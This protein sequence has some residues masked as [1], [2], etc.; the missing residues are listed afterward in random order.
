MPLIVD[1]HCDIAWNIESFGRDYTRS[2]AESREAEKGSRAVEINEETLIGIPE[3]R[4]GNVGLVFG[5]LFAAPNRHNEGKWD[6]LCYGTP[7]EAHRL[8]MG[9]VDVYY[10]LCESHPREFRL[11]RSRAELDEHL[12]DWLA[13]GGKDQPVGLVLLMEGADGI[14]SIDELPEW[15]ARGVRLIGLAWAGTRY[16][17]GTKEPGP[18]TA[19]GRELLVGMA[20]HGFVLDV[21]H[22]DEVA[23]LEATDRYEGT[24]VASHVNCLALLPDFPTNRHLSDNALRRIIERDG[25]I[26]NVP[27][28]NFLKSG[29]SRTKGSSRDEV[30]LDTFAAHI[31]H[32]CQLAGDSLHS[33]IGADYDGGFGLQSVPPEIDSVAD[34]QRVA[35]LL[36]ARGYT[37]A[38]IDNIMGLNWIRVLH[39]TLPESA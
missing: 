30:T 29:W 3:Y 1:A 5:T 15:H 9:Q 36:E 32:V 17:G 24:L 8:Y 34:L 35:P 4:K 38:D 27:V 14:R 19:D 18:L 31:D 2:V 33:G 20:E 23:A 16:S 11:V 37:A 12:A 39:K 21:S 7:D 10:R 25:V 6:K 13:T 28:N 26:G 22:M